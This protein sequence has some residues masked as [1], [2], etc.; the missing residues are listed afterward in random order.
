MGDAIFTL[1]MPREIR[2]SDESRGVLYLEGLTRSFVG[3]L[4]ELQ[5]GR[6]TCTQSGYNFTIM[7]SWC[8]RVVLIVI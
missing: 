2:G 3:N 8:I 1:D 5:T 7:R 6:F 4:L